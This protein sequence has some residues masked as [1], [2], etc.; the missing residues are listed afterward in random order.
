MLMMRA[1]LTAS[2]MATLGVLSLGCRSDASA[3]DRATFTTAMFVNA[4]ESIV[5]I[6]NVKWVGSDTVER[7][8]ILRPCAAHHGGTYTVIVR[9]AK[10][11]HFAPN[12]FIM[13]GYGHESN[14]KSAL[15][16]SAVRHVSNAEL[17]ASYPHCVG[18]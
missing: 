14:S 3:V 4:P 16:D 15:E 11:A 17:K 7:N 10:A 5:K 13:T 8:T 12:Q 9:H 2:C 6:T 18:A 1:W